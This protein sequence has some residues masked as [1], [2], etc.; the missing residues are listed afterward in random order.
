MS[1][2][3]DRYIVLPV[4]ARLLAPACLPLI[5]L[6]GK[7]GADLWAWITR[8]SS[9]LVRFTGRALVA[10]G[11]LGLTLMSLIA[12]DLGTLPN[13]TGVVAWNAKQAAQFLRTYPSITVATDSRSARALQ[14]YRHYNP[15]DSFVGFE[16]ALQSES[17]V[18]EGARKPAFVVRNGPIIHEREITGQRYGRRYPSDGDRN[19]L[20][21][22][23]PGPGARVFSASLHPEPRFATLVGYA[24][25]RKLL[26]SWDG[27]QSE[28][29]PAT[30]ASLLEV[31]VFRLGERRG[32]PV[33]PAAQDGRRASTAAAATVPAGN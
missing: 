10:V 4:T 28:R 2:S 30:D 6:S 19:V 14:F 1:V 32:A 31:Q 18:D 7:L 5:M 16:A 23:L 11:A 9:V 33:R 22:F 21:E 8:T 26:S 3:L 20:D 27:P 12:M 24:P 29:L 17:R 13:L 15:L 25:I